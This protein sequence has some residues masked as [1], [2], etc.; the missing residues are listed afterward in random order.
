MFEPVAGPKDKKKDPE[1][2]RVRREMY[3]RQRDANGVFKPGPC[4][5]YDA[6]KMQEQMRCDHPL[7]H[8]SGAATIR[9]CMLR[10]PAA[11]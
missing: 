9:A 4:A 5:K 7:R 10:A 6:V 11:D 1:K 8:S 3:N 2:E